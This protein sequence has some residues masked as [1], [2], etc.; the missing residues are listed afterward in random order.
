MKGERVLMLPTPETGKFPDGF[1]TG[2]ICYWTDDGHHMLYLPSGGLGN[3]DQ[4]TVTNH[5][6]GTITVSPSI[7]LTRPGNR[8]VRRH[9]F[10]RRGVWEPCGDDRPHTK[11]AHDVP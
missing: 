2:S 11:G 1:D 7:L 8:E 4:H 3:L 9:G 10:I 5:E 6:D